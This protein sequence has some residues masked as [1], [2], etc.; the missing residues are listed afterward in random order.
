MSPCHIVSCSTAA[1]AVKHSSS[2]LLTI[3]P[4]PSLGSTSDLVLQI[5]VAC[6]AASHLVAAIPRL[7]NVASHDLTCSMPLRVT[8]PSFLSVISRHAPQALDVATHQLHATNP[9]ISPVLC[10]HGPHHTPPTIPSAA[11]SSTPPLQSRQLPIFKLLLPLRAHCNCGHHRAP[12]SPPSPALS[13]TF[14][15]DQGI[16]MVFAALIR[17]EDT[18]GFINAYLLCEIFFWSTRCSL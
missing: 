7:S 3:S 16:H 18:V 10:G 17:A 6:P 13:T 1:S 9:A 8:P 4:A 14:N 11:S 12:R 15:V 2:H 5:P